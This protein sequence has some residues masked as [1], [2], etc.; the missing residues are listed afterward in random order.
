MKIQMRYNF[1]KKNDKKP[2]KTKGRFLSHF[3]WE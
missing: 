3:A 2:A 1:D